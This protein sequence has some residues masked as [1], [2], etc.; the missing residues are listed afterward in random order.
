MEAILDLLTV[1][2]FYLG[3]SLLQNAVQGHRCQGSRFL[4]NTLVM[5]GHPPP[6]TLLQWRIHRM[7][8]F[9]NGFWCF[10]G[11]RLWSTLSCS[12][13]L[14]ILSFI[15]N[16]QTPSGLVGAFSNLLIFCEADVTV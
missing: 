12:S 1:L 7:A 15:W 2:G 14:F 10:L 5:D 4:V 13:V 11:L 16:S 8:S 3:L 9:R 6:H